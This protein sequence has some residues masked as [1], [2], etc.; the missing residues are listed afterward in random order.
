MKKG[1]L[2]GMSVAMLM[3]SSIASATVTKENVD[4][5][6][7]IAPI[8]ANYISDSSDGY[9]RVIQLEHDVYVREMVNKDLILQVD[10]CG[11]GSV[12]NGITVG[13]LFDPKKVTDAKLIASWE[14][15]EMKYYTFVAPDKSIIRFNTHNGITKSIT[16][17]S[18]TLN[19]GA[20]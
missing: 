3:S 19:D 17:I 4:V 14:R 2:V 5:D 16:R 18:K 9:V 11:T 10:Y 1:I 7:E 15:D 6:M 8:H 20:Y 13:N 12:V